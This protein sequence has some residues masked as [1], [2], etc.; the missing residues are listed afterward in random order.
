MDFARTCQCSR[1]QIK[2]ALISWSNLQIPY[3]SLSVTS[4]KYGIG[5]NPHIPN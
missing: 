3:K 5:T 2:E 1:I 4:V